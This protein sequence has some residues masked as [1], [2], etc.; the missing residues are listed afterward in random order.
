M[1]PRLK[2]C[3]DFIS[4]FWAGNGYAPSFDEIKDGLNAKSKS[5]VAALVDKLEAR[6]YITRIPNLARSIRVVGSTNTPD[7]VPA[8]PEPTPQPEKSDAG[9]DVPWA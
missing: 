5:S 3:L 8:I 1:T 7:E 6:G 2:E 4:G 9:D